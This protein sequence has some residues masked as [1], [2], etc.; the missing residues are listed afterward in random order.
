MSH[1]EAAAFVNLSSKTLYNLGTKGPKR[2]KVGKYWHYEKA[3]L[4]AWI[5]SRT[6]IAA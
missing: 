6:K 1:K 2:K 4:I 5:A 3:D